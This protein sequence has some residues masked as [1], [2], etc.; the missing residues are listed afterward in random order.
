[1]RSV[2]LKARIAVLQMLDLLGLF[3]MAIFFSCVGLFLISIRY[4]AKGCIS[5]II[6]FLVF[7][8]SRDQLHWEGT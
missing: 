2:R 1:M 6:I 3:V 8:F 5:L 7:C 4:V